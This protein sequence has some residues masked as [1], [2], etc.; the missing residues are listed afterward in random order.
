MHEQPLSDKHKKYIESLDIEADAQR[1]QDELNICQEAIDYFR[2]SNALLKAGVK[3][4]LTLYDIAILCCR[5]DNLAEVPSM[6]EK[7]FSMASE[8]AHAAVENE[9]WHHSA[10]SRA[11]VEQLTPHQ[12]RFSVLTTESNSSASRPLLKSASSAGIASLPSNSSSGSLGVPPFV[13]EEEGDVLPGMAQSAASDSS[14]EN[15]GH[16]DVEDCGEWAANVIADVSVDQI[17]PVRPHRSA[18]N[19]SDEGSKDSEQRG[20]WCVN[21]GSYPPSIASDDGSYT[22]SPQ[23]TPRGSMHETEDLPEL[24]L[25]AVCL[26]TPT[27][28]FTMPTG[29]FIPPATVDIGSTKNKGL[30]SL[31]FAKPDTSSG[32]P[33][34]KSYSSLPRGKAMQQSAPDKP[35]AYGNYRKYFHNFIDLVIV[36]ET[37]AALRTTS[38]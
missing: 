17:V 14:S 18:S 11:I 38:D 32:M 8:L 19:A 21:P 29:P 3:A 13:L 26:K 31:M 25:D 20:F 23:S 1:L 28:S 34:S 9:R 4:G 7:L 10:A 2:A 22:W 27:V 37:T 36:R 35:E 5:N 30:S 12:R 33:R 15:E 16:V 24:S 6:M